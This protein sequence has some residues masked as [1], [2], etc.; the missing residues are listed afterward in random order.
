MVT[1]ISG[2]GTLFISNNLKGKILRSLV[3]PIFKI[4][5]NHKNQ[6]IIIQN[7]DDL[8]VLLNWGVLNSAKAKLIKGSGVNLEDYANIDEPTGIPVVCFAARLLKDKGVY[9][10]IQQHVCLSKEV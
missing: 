4:S 6:K 7:K 5:L 8:N 1:A 3:Y 10:Y 9:E 2:L